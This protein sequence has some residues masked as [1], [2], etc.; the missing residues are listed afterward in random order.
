MPCSALS[1]SASDAGEI[2]DGRQSEHGYPGYERVSVAAA[3]P[4]PNHNRDG[5]EDKAC[6]CQPIV[7]LMLISCSWDHLNCFRR[8]ICAPTPGPPRI[9][10]RYGLPTKSGRA[11]HDF[12]GGPSLSAV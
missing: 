1:I 6:T 4:H 9:W 2:D 11:L 5:Q 3:N 7:R 8:S 12:R 10:K